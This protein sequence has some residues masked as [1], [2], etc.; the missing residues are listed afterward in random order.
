MSRL[1]VHRRDFG[2]FLVLFGAI[3]FV[4]MPVWLSFLVGSLAG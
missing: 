4:T 1:R 2:L 3:A